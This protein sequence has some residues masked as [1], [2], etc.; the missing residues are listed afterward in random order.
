M[1]REN[2]K[3]GEVYRHFKGGLYK[4][5]TIALHRDRRRT[6]NISGTLRQI[7]SIRK[8]SGYVYERGGYKEVSLRKT[9]IPHGKTNLGCIVEAMALVLQVELEKTKEDT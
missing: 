9:K 1:N 2:P 5:I 6:C 8:T 3:A 4:V 7:R